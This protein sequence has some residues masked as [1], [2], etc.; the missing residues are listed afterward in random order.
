MGQSRRVNVLLVE[1]EC[2]ISEVI[3]EALT[4]RGYAVHSVMTAEEALQH[5]AAGADVDLLFTDINLPGGMDG[6][7]L[8]T[9]IRET[10]PDLPVIYASGRWGL[11][12]QL[13]SVPRSQVL[14]KPYSVTR[15]CAAVE[16]L[17]GDAPA[18]QKELQQVSV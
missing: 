18:G 8:A 1:D 17:L 3:S 6:A 10:R 9:R 13:R 11:L 15:A 12:E 14:P 4:D 16:E 2:L 7:L 5:L